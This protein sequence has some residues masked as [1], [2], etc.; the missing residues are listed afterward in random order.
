MYTKKDEVRVAYYHIRNFRLV[1]A[2]NLGDQQNSDRYEQADILEKVINVEIKMNKII[3]MF[4][5]NSSAW[6][7][8]YYEL[9]NNEDFKEIILRHYRVMLDTLMKLGYSIS[10]AGEGNKIGLLELFRTGKIDRDE[11]IHFCLICDCAEGRITDPNSRP[12]SKK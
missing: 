10:L 7:Q 1:I 8:L 3:A 12:F 5:L 9:K 11:Y 6:E 2:M 4:E